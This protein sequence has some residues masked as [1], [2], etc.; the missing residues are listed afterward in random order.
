IVQRN[1]I[2]VQS[3][4]MLHTTNTPSVIL[5]DLEDTCDGQE[6]GDFTVIQSSLRVVEG[7][8]SGSE[9]SVL[10]RGS[11]VSTIFDWIDE[12]GID[13][14][15][16]DSTTRSISSWKESRKVTIVRSNIDSRTRRVDEKTN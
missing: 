13:D 4:G 5:K 3:N 15:S 8:L 1:L 12:A 2:L 14:T 11:I 10:A 16:F 9:T 7:F 6:K